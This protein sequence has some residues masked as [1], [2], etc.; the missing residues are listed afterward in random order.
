MRLHPHSIARHLDAGTGTLL[1]G[2][3]AFLPLLPCW[4]P[5]WLLVGTLR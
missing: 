2:S 4:R 3:S 1:E 5:Q